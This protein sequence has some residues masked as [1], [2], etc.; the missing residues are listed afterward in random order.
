MLGTMDIPAAAAGPWLVVAVALGIGG[1]ALTAVVARHVLRRRRAAGP[2]AAPDPAESP[3]REDDLP[4][5]LERPPGSAGRPDAPLDGWTVLSGPTGPAVASTP[6][7]PAGRRDWS[8][9]VLTTAGVVAALLLLGAGVS[10]GVAAARRDGAGTRGPD[11]GQAHQRGPQHLSADLAFEG[12]VFERHAVGV[13]ATYP[14]VRLTSNGTAALAQVELPTWN[15]LADEAPADPVAAGCSRTLPEYADVATPALQLQRSGDGQVRISGRFPT[16]TR[17]NGSPPE[18]TGRVYELL[19]TVGPAAGRSGT[20]QV[21][22][23]G[24]LRLGTDRARTTGVS[25]LRAGD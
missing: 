11:R 23:T 13:T 14:R 8:L 5:F 10:A 3:F 18:R 2:A 16:Y 9:P 21:P 7:A 6:P 4:G 25:V 15:C 12:I 1:L 22:A 20:G 24:E 17:P 19:I